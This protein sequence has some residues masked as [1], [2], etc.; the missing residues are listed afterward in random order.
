[1]SNI[2]YLLAS[3]TWRQEEINAINEVIASDM[4]TMGSRVKQFEQEYAQHFGHGHAV[5]CN[6]GPSTN[7]LML[8]LLKLKYK[9]TGDIVVITV[10]DVGIIAS[11]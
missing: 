1:M 6:S 2:I 11:I 10:L 5:M 4:Y 8:S 9:L 7:L 3:T